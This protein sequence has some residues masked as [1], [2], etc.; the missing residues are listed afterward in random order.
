[1]KVLVT[2]TW[3]KQQLDN[4]NLII[5]DSS[6]QSNVSGLKAPYTGIKI[7]NARHF[8]LKNTFSDKESTLPNTLPKPE[9][10][11]KECQKLGINKDSII[12]VYDALGIYTSPRI[13]WM[14]KTIGHNNVAILNG[15]LPSWVEQ[16]LPTESLSVKSN[17]DFG[18]FKSEIN[19]SLLANMTDV[20]EATTRTD[21]AIIDARSKARFTGEAPEPRAN[22]SSGHMPN[23]YNI[24]FKEVL[25]QYEYASVEDL[26][27]IFNRIPKDKTHYIFSCGSGL[28]ACIIALASTIVNDNT[29]AIYDGSWTEWAEKQ[30]HLIQKN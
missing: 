29:F 26:T 22:L 27:N 24:P 3:L 2:T 30:P 20:I 17:W 15:G 8:D 16:E 13:W 11:E 5:L 6:P 1:M 21:I 9:Y 7:K 25:D 10:F 14:F 19:T 28:T 23:A 18:N 12:V 4:P